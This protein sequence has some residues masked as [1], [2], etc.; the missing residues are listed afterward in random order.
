MD[1]KR[2]TDNAWLENIVYN[3]HDEENIFSRY[4]FSVSN[5]KLLF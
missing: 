4:L 5:A 1:D 3:Y 2:N